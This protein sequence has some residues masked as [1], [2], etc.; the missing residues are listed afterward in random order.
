MPVMSSCLWSWW[1]SLGGHEMTMAVDWVRIRY[2]GWPSL[3]CVFCVMSPRNTGALHSSLLFHRSLTAL[4]EAREHARVVLVWAPVERSL[5]A[6]KRTREE[7]ELL[8][9]TL[10]GSED[11]HTPT[12]ACQWL[13]QNTRESAFEQWE[14]EWLETLPDP[15]SISAMSFP[16]PPSSANH[17]LWKAAAKAPKL[18][19]TRSPDEPRHS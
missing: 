4:F 2:A 15:C 6:V 7:V 12:E 8:V 13:L 19:S 1:S 5:H 3:C 18:K 10:P 17:L 14:T 9:R 16:E 11:Q